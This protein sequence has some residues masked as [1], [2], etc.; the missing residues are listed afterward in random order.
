MFSVVIEISFVCH[1]ILDI[2]LNCTNRTILAWVLSYKSSAWGSPALTV[3]WESLG[4]WLVLSCCTVVDHEAR[5]LEASQ[6]RIALVWEGLCCLH[7]SV[8]A[9]PTSNCDGVGRALITRQHG[10]PPFVELNLEIF[11]IVLAQVIAGN[12]SHERWYRIAGP[13]IAIQFTR[14]VK[15]QIGRKCFII[16][17][18]ILIFH[19]FCQAAL[20][21]CSGNIHRQKSEQHRFHFWWHYMY[22]QIKINNL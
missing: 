6:Q 5:R 3:R 8:V 14:I 10:F 9:E 12:P 13:E 4:K 18:C 1:R 20:F 16:T 11:S 19:I 2:W 22:Y 21:T 15:E 17:I 7:P